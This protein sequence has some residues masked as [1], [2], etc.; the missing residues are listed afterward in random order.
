MFLMFGH[1]YAGIG[2]LWS[3]NRFPPPKRHTFT[4]GNVYNPTFCSKNDE[5]GVQICVFLNTMSGLKRFFLSFLN[6]FLRVVYSVHTFVS[7]S[8]PLLLALKN[9][10]KYPQIPPQ[11]KLGCKTVLTGWMRKMCLE[12]WPNNPWKKTRHS[13]VQ[14]WL[15]IRLFANSPKP[16][17]LKI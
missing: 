7:H 4:T 13:R 1:M 16:L 6:T 15:F 3:E 12:N 14:L 2:Y 10:P 5:F 17:T 9:L 11:R 8:C